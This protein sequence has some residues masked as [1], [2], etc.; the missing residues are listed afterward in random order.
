MEAEGARAIYSELGAVPVIN[1]MGN[2]TMLGGS[3]PSATVR[4]A[5]EQ[6]GRFYVD[7]DQLLEG[8]GRVVADL[9]GCEAALVTPGCAAALLLGT[10]AC[11][12]GDDPERM[13]RL[14]DTTGMKGE[15]VIQAPQHYKYERVVRMAGVR[16]VAA[17]SADSCTGADLEASLNRQTAAVLYPV[18][19]G[20]QDGFLPLAQ[21]LDIAH[22]AGVPVIADAA[23]QV[24]P[25]DVFRQTASCGADLV[26]FGAKYFG[27]PNSS[28][29]LCGRHDLIDAARA[30]TFAAFE[31]RELPGYGRPLK[32]DRQEVVGVVTALREWLDPASQDER[33]EAASRRGRLLRN[34]LRDLAGAELI[35][36][37]GDRV[38]GL[39][40]RL[41]G[42]GM[43]GP[44]LADR[45]RRED[46]AIWAYAEGDSISFGMHTVQDGDE[47]AIAAAVKR[48][49]SR[50]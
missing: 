24:S 14:P 10:A 41:T 39:R 8:S 21:V 45:L 34:L 11:V 16:L 4:A 7:M 40:L 9:L 20:S 35:P 6:A 19:G 23:Y 5:M 37:E 29:L 17:G 33:D 46:P 43:D 42:G 3:S 18:L 26:G 25:L 48:A 22:A 50:S 44:A 27:A 2:L 49:L 32:I 15:V 12:A 1:A 13:S 47:S 38:T 31:R 36:L 30:H 28:G